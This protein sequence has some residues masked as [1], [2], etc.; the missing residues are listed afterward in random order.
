MNST[1]SFALQVQKD[2]CTGCGLC[3]DTCAY[4]AIHVETYP[5]IDPYACRLCG[6]CVQACPAE[7][8]VMDK[9]APSRP[10]LPALPHKASGSWPK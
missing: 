7:A 1:S 4:N 8:L 10:I 9:P 6:S 5:E 3:A 2:R